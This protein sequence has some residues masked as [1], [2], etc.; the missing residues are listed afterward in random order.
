M[1]KWT[2]E[3]KLFDNK[4][5]KDLIGTQTD[6]RHNLGKN[7]ISISE[8]IEM[9]KK[10][11]LHILSYVQKTNVELI[12]LWS[13]QHINSYPLIKNK[14]NAWSNNFERTFMLLLK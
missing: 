7:V 12:N 9:A 1:E 4:L 5:P 3:I 11:I 8:G 6:I 10:L 13:W 2:P 14:K